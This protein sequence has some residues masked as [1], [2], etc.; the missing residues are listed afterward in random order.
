MPTSSWPPGSAFRLAAGLACAGLALAGGPAA[1]QVYGGQ[2]ANGTIVL[3]YMASTEAPD[4]LVSAP[5]APP[6]LPAAKS[7]A[8]LALPGMASTTGGPVPP[9]PAHYRALILKVA[10]EQDVPAPLLAA[11]A[12]AESGFN[13]KARSPKGA[14]GLMQLMPDTARRFQVA[15]RLS[16]EQSMRGAAA[17]LRWLSGQFQADLPKVIAAYNAGEQAVFRAGGTPPFAETQAY[18]PRVLGFM[19]HFSRVFEQTPV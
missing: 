16:P 19:K 5:P 8:T 18:L 14:L 9:M 4:L 13:A 1:A 6:A 10:K 7:T 2:Q 15:D 12:A 11:V 17:Y 3:S